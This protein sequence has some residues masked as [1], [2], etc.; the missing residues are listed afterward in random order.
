M[1]YINSKGKVLDNRSPWSID[2]IKH[3]FLGIWMIIVAFSQPPA[4]LPPPF[5]SFATMAS[6]SAHEDYRTAA[7]KKKD[8]PSGSGGGGGGGGGNGGGRP[9]IVGLSNLQTDPRTGNMGGCPGGCC[10]R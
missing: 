8:P 4:Q 6:R 1:T 2:G 10:G 7:H 5:A 9:R 3:F